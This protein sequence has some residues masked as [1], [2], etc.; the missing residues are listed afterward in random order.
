[1]LAEEATALCEELDR[2]LDHEPGMGDEEMQRI[3]DIA[4]RFEAPTA[5]W[6]LVEKARKTAAVM[7][8]WTDPEA[9]RAYGPTP[10][11]LRRYARHYVREL[12][13]AIQVVLGQAGQVLRKPV[14]PSS[15]RK[16]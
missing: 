15:S 4:S 10:D 11:L 8:T 2:M 12:T 13:L 16:A 9:W 3:R 14:S 1:M 5:A 7:E 6:L